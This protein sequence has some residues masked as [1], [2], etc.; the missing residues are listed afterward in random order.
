[1]SVNTSV[2]LWGTVLH[3]YTFHQP[4]SFDHW[5][6]NTFYHGR[7]DVFRIEDNIGVNELMMFSFPKDNGLLL[8]FLEPGE[9]FFLASHTFFFPVSVVELDHSKNVRLKLVVNAFN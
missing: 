4:K 2:K 7:C 8:Y 5:T 3:D 6:M 1:M 9:D